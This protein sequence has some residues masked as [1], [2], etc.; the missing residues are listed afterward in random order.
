M[1]GAA[2][3]VDP[4]GITVTIVLF[5]PDWQPDLDLVDNVATSLE[6]FIT[7]CSGDAY[8]DG[9]IA[10]FQYA[11]PVYTTSLQVRKTLQC[12]AQYVFSLLDCKRFV[13][14]VFQALDGASFVFVA[15]PAFKNAESAG[16]RKR[17]LLAQFVSTN[18][19]VRNEKQFS[20]PP[21]EET[22]TPYRRH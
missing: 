2:L 17:H 19:A 9:A 7:M 3:A 13:S 18:G 6:R 11:G 1:G 8:P 16:R 22:T 15:H 4:P 21:R 12:L 10:D 5:L 20:H 14:F